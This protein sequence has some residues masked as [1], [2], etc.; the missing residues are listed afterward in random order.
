MFLWCFPRYW[1]NVFIFK[2]C[3]LTQFFTLLLNL[4]MK[5]V[6]T[7]G[8]MKVYILCLILVS[9]NSKS[10]FIQICPL[11][12]FSGNLP[13]ICL[14]IGKTPKEMLLKVKNATQWRELNSLRSTSPFWINPLSEYFTRTNLFR[15]MNY[16][17]KIH[18]ILPEE[19]VNK[20]ASIKHRPKKASYCHQNSTDT[21]RVDILIE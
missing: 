20:K 9:S 13:F 7:K 12:L 2:F 6:S 11:M 15:D 16:V 14:E 19:W 1:E 10:I 5:M 21:G 17:V 8:M 18:Q 4:M 3:L